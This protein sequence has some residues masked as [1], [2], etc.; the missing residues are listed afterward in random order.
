MQRSLFQHYVKISYCRIREVVVFLN[1]LSCFAILGP[2]GLNEPS[3]IGQI[4]FICQ[5]RPQLK[6][7]DVFTMSLFLVII[8][9]ALLEIIINSLCGDILLEK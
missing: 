1:D 2:I 8:L 4:K 3:W 5:Y 7:I 6:Q 9:E